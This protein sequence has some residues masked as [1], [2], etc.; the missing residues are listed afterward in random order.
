MST[1]S[2]IGAIV[3][4]AI[5]FFVGGPAGA[6]YGAALGAGVGAVV[7]GVGISYDG[8]RLSDLSV[9]TSTYGADIP[10]VHSTIV[11]SG[12]VLWLENNK[13]RERV[14]KVSSGG[15][16]VLIG[17]TYGQTAVNSLLLI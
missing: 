9:Q 7:G 5:G 15:K 4:G 10:R 8:P 13:L 12:N 14:R 6:L 17:G 16:G 3:G 1:Q 11:V 2:A